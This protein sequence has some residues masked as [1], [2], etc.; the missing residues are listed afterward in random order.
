[1][2]KVIRPVLAWVP[3]VAAL[4]VTGGNA[5]AQTMRTMTSARQVWGREPIEMDVQYGAGTLRIDP[6]DAP[7]LY[8]MELRYDEDV[9]TPVAEY[10][11]EN[12]R[13][14]LGVRSPEGSRRLNVR[15]G[16][17]ATISI[18]R[19]VPLDLDLDFGAGEAEID[20]SGVSL[21]SLSLS[22]GASETRVAF[23]APNPIQA[24]RISIEAGAASL[25]V[26]GLGN[27]RAE[28]IEFKGGVG[29]TV[30]D[31]G[32]E[33]SHSATASVEMGVGSLTLRLPRSQGIRVSRSSFLTSFSAR[34]LE[35]RDNAYFSDN[36]DTAQHKL[37]IDV[38]A[39]LGSIDIQW[40]D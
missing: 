28:R 37:T 32:G 38:S 35:R 27:A 3:L 7:Y 4:W 9:F 22:T 19:E 6:A 11:Q 17:R 12:R 2:R 18:T 39:A 30:L 10:D 40:I 31:F 14:R 24:E 20:L 25:R 15:E 36:W 29:A 13:L 26:T 33:W 23:E 16:S 21:R 34:G 8:R 5:D 1:M